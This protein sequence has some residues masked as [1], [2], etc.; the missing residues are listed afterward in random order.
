MS[1]KQKVVKGTVW[2]LLERI[3][4]QA[5]GFVLTLVLAEGL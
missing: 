5:V 2:A 3:S 4:A 1:L